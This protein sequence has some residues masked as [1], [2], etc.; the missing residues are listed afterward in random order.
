[1]GD[2]CFVNTFSKYLKQMA[3]EEKK[4]EMEEEIPDKAG[5]EKK[6]PPP[7]ETE[8]YEILEVSV[9]ATTS[10]IKK[11]YF[12]KAR[13]CHPDK[14]P[15]NPE[16]EE[17]FK[18]ISTAYEVLSDP[19]KREMYHKHGK[20]GVEFGEVDP[21]VMFT[22]LFGGGKFDQYI[23][24]L[25][26]FNDA[27]PEDATMEEYTAANKERVEMLKQKLITKLRPWMEGDAQGFAN[28]VV[29]EANELKKE[30]YGAEL[31][32][33]IGYIYENEAKQHLK[34]FLGLSGLAAE[35][36]EKAHMVKEFVVLLNEASKTMELEEAIEIAETDDMRSELEA[37]MF[38]QSI[39]AMWRMAK[40]DIEGAIREACEATLTDPTI[41]KA[42]RKRR[43]LGVKL[44]GKAW[45]NITPEQGKEGAWEFF[46]EMDQAF[47]A[48]KAENDASKWKSAWVPGKHKRITNGE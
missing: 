19:E 12:L 46:A 29:E 20:S 22:M 2:F 9:D 28:S 6:L 21:V 25:S 41:D 34:G 38:K 10:Q 1:M 33:H 5:E 36:K 17:Q 26:L 35:I 4:E 37:A 32:A 3:E 45:K 15:D 7:K 8:F 43:A 23:G 48:A 40:M 39:V 30:S 13:K 42:S 24:E 31:L 44:I 18:L 14:N 27:L 16:A 47:S 11:S